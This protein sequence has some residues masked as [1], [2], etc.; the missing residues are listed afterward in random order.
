[1]VASRA[2]STLSQIITAAI[3]AYLNRL[4]GADEIILGMTVTARLGAVT[5]NL[6]MLSNVL[7]L[8]LMACADMTV[9]Q[10]IQQGGQKS[11]QGL[12]HQRYRSEEL[13]RE[14][15]LTAANRRLFGPTV[16]VM[17][18]DYD[19]SFSGHSATTHNL[20][21]GVAED[22]SI[23]VYGRSEDGGLRVDFD[24]N[25]NLYTIDDLLTHQR[26]FLMF[27]ETVA[28]NPEERIGRI[29]LLTAEERRQIL[30]AR[31]KTARAIP[32]V[33][34]VELF[35]E[36]VRR[37]PEAE[38]VI[39]E[40][41][42]L[43]YRELNERAN[44][45]AH[46][47]IGEGVGPEVVVAL[48]L[49][50]SLEMVVALLG[51]LKAGA[52]Y[53][54]I[55]ADYP[56]QR[57]AYMLEDA[58]PYCVLTMTEFTSR[59][60]GGRH[61]LH[62]DGQEMIDALARCPTNNPG[63]QNRAT[64]LAPIT[65]A[66]VIYTSGSTGAPKG[67]VIPHSAIVNKISTLIGYLDISQ[68]TRYAATSPIIFD[69]LLEQIFC[70]LCAGGTSVIVPDSIRDDA[71][72]FS[73]YAVEHRLSVLDLT[74]G[75]VEH[76]IQNGSWTVRLDA[77]IVGGDVL[78]VDIANEGVVGELYLAGAGLA[79]VWC[80]RQSKKTSTHS[81]RAPRYG[82][83]TEQCCAAIAQERRDKGR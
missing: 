5:R 17:L 67:V 66:Y 76:L 23:V 73:A 19:L 39:Y 18:F 72:R 61:L 21:T 37:T 57:L 71:E 68:A 80:Q 49:P 79:R 11:R 70:P 65:P 32:Q 74:P 36:Q 60:N 52:A 14:L 29:D 25:P 9:S 82:H 13:S 54:P 22:I 44:R 55:D 26:R 53:L 41:Q 69:P 33:T 27:L 56:A 16:N 63:D 30:E 75:L 4:T 47:L 15:G 28:G 51:I 45:L 43:T 62:L 38:A 12:R 7:P 59:L 64:T 24:A 6:G 35:E 2:G 46:L 31:N 81:F 3:A 20:S 58:Q 42:E 34:L 40:E 77:L 1:M 48:A 50:R 8:R 10:L 83:S 78:P